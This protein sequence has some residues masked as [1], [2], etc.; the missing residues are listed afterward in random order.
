MH[1]NTALA[2]T[3]EEQAPETSRAEELHE[4]VAIHIAD[5]SIRKMRHV[6]VIPSGYSFRIPYT[7]V[8]W[9]TGSTIDCSPPPDLHHSIRVRR[10]RDTSSTGMS[11]VATFNLIIVYGLVTLPPIAVI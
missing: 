7:A 11:H 2:Q 5:L 6:A 4:T 10:S 3:D 1:S 8:Q 9:Q